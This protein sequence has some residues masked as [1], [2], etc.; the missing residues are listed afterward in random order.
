M[1]VRVASSSCNALSVPLM[2][3]SSARLEWTAASPMTWQMS[4]AS[5]RSVELRCRRPGS[6]RQVRA[7]DADV[8]RANICMVGY[9]VA[10]FITQERAAIGG[11][12]AGLIGAAIARVGAAIAIAVADAALRA[13]PLA[14]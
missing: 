10:I 1:I 4:D 11:R 7:D 6:P 12:G 3:A 5:R 13:T 8:G 2:S 9:A 14:Q